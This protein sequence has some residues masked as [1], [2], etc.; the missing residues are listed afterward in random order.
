MINIKKNTSL[1]TL[2]LV[3]ATISLSACGGG[4]ASKSSAGLNTSM[5][6]KLKS[7]AIDKAMERA[8]KQAEASG[9][10]QEILAMLAQIHGRNPDDAIVAT[11][12]GRALREDDQI[13]IAIRTLKPFATGENKNIEATTEM[14]MTQI[15]LGDFK[16]A[17]NYAQSAI[18]MNSKNA[19]AYLALGTA[20]DAQG[21]HQD[22]EISFRAGL[23]NWK[24]D[25][26]PI[27]NNLALNLASQGHLEESLSLLEK[28]LKI[29]P[30]RMDLERNRRIIATLVETSGPRAPAPNAKPKEKVA[31]VEIPNAVKPP[32]KTGKNAKA[33]PKKKPAQ[34]KV[35]EVVKAEKEVTTSNEKTIK[36]FATPVRDAPA[37]MKLNNIGLKNK[38][39]YN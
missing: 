4:T 14:A 17:E 33:T 16:A 18:D 22:A 32:V 9:N 19:R 13:N 21:R 12:Y 20:Q 25:P 34:G 8:M 3:L 24:G 29:S 11:R 2:S 35:K 36:D 28:A 1:I 10:K 31:P 30:R 6:P 7:S 23:K 26:T 39:S 27:L 38:S 37:K 15:A 5:N